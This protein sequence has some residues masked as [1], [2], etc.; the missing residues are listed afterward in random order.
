[1]RRAVVEYRGWKEGYRCGYCAS[2]QGKVS[3]GERGEAGRVRCRQPRRC[4]SATA[5][6]KDGGARRSVWESAVKMSGPLFP[7]GSARAVPA[8]KMAAEAAS[9]RRGARC[10][11]AGGRE[12]P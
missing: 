1:M 11:A 6:T 8:A 5:L 4:G 3:A 12:L 10:E 2:A 7:A 9:G